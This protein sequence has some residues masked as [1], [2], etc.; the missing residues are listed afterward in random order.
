MLALLGGDASPFLEDKV[1][2]INPFIICLSYM[3]VLT[4]VGRKSCN[5]ERRLDDEA[6]DGDH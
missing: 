4:Y 6:S 1:M 2:V 3:Y 5:G